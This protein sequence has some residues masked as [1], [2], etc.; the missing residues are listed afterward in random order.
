MIKDSTV[1]FVKLAPSSPFGRIEVENAMYLSKIPRQKF[2]FISYSKYLYSVRTR[3]DS[4]ILY[5]C[6]EIYILFPA[7]S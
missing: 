6:N 5:C 4:F 3:A 2:A 7:L 1:L